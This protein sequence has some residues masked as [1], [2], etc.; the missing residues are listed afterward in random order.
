M[1]RRLEGTT[2]LTPAGLPAAVVQ[3][4]LRVVFPMLGHDMGA[5]RLG[6][7]KVN[8]AD[9][10]AAEVRTTLNHL[11]PLVGSPVVVLLVAER[12]G[13]V[14]EWPEVTAYF[15]DLWYPG[16]DDLLVLGTATGGFVALSHEE[17]LVYGEL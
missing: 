11:E 10:T 12:D 5:S 7:K 4:L 9:A 6:S 16:S 1:L 15:D 17:E 13:V 14:M 2:A 3:L 8:V